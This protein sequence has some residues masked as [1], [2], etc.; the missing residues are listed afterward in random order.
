MVGKKLTKLQKA[1]RQQNIE[2]KHNLKIMLNK[3]LISE[4]YYNK[5][6]KL[7]TIYN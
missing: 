1:I 3:G 2:K 6:V 5:K 4:E 7:I